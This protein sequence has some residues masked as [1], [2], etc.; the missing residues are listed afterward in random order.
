M[1]AVMDDSTIHG[2]HG[3]RGK[4]ERGTPG[5]GT[6]A[7]RPRVGSIVGRWVTVLVTAAMVASGLTVIDVAAAP[8]AQAA[9]ITVPSG[10]DVQAQ[11]Q[12]HSGYT[13][14]APGGTANP[15]SDDDYRYGSA[16]NGT[17]TGSIS[18][19]GGS[20][21][22]S[23]AEYSD[24]WTGW[25]TS[26][27][28]A[29]TSHGNIS[30]SGGQLSLSNQSALGFAPT[31]ISSFTTGQFF[32]LGRVA[33][34]NNPINVDND[35]FQGDLNLKFMGMN[36]GYRWQM[37]ETPNNCSGAGCSD[38][39]V[40]F[41]NQISSQTFTNNGFT[42]TLVVQGFVA[43]QGSNNTCTPTLSSVAGVINQF[44]TVEGTTTYGCLYASVE[45]VRPITVKKVVNSPYGTAP[46]DAFTFSRTSTHAG[47]DWSGGNF[48]LNANGS[49]TGNYNTGEAV[50]IA[51]TSPAAPWAF[52]SAVCVDGTG[53]AIA[54]VTVNG[55]Q[56]S[57]P[58]GT[59]AATVAALAIT[60]TYTNTY[61][62]KA[63]LTLQK[64]VTATG[65]P[66]PQAQAS[67]WTLTAQGQGAV[68]AQKVQGAG[69]SPAVISQTVIAGSYALSET[70][71]GGSKTS[72]Y[73]Q[74]GP[75]TCWVTGS[76]STPVTVTGGVVS[77]TNGQN[78]TCQVKNK[79]QTGTLQ[80]TKTVTTSPAGGYTQGTAMAFTAKYVC[81][82]S[83]TTGTVT[84]NPNATNG[85]PGAAATINN[86]PAGDSCVVTE[87]SPPS[88]STN[89]VNGSWL[90]NAPA[91]PAPATITAGGTATVNIGNS[92]TQ[93][94]G[95]LT[96]G[97]VI[98]PRPGTPAAGYTGG[99][100]RSFGVGYSCSIGSTVV[101]SGTVTV[102]TGTAASITGVPAT[103]NCVVTEDPSSTQPG[104]FPD[105]SYH[106]DGN[107]VAPASVTVPVNGTANATVTN[108]FKRELVSLVLKKVVTGA[109]YSGT[110]EDFTVA[111][112][113]GSVTN[114]SVTLAA[115]GSK[116]VQVPAGVLCAISETQPSGSL[117]AAGYVWDT[118]VYTGLT[119]GSVTVPLGETR[120]VTVTNNNRVG[121]AR[122][123][124]T[125]AIGDNAS[126]VTGGPQF[127]ISVTCNAPA[128]GQSANYSQTFT[129]SWPNPGT[130]LT[131]YLPIGTS[132]TVTE[133]GLPT[134]NQNLTDG[135]YAWGAAPD[136]QT[137]QVPASTQPLSVT[138][139][140]TITRVTGAF[141]VAK[142]VTNNTGATPS[143]FSGTYTCTYAPQSTVVSGTWVAPAAGGPATLT[144]GGASV[145]VLV[146]SSCVV[147][148]NA[149]PLPGGDSSYSWST[150]IP[151]AVG[152][153]AG[154]TATSTVANTLN[155]STGSFS[156]TKSV[157][158]GQA[159]VAFENSDFTFSYTCTPQS[160]AV[161][162][163]TLTM[164]AGGSAS[165][166]EVIPVGSNCVVTETATAAPIDPFTWDGVSYT[167]NGGSANSQSAQ[168]TIPVGGATV[169]VNATNTISRKTVNLTV[170][171]TVVAPD[172]GFV[173]AGM[174]FPVTVT[175]D[176]V[177]LGTKNLTNGGS[178]TWA[179][180][181]GSTCS[182]SEAQVTG[183]LA[184]ASFAWGPVDVNP[185]SVTLDSVNGQ[186]SIAVTNTVT[187]VYGQIALRKVF[188]NGGFS[189][190]VP[191]TQE[192]TGTWSCTYGNQPAVT[193]TWSALA[194]HPATM[195]GD[196]NH[197]LLTSSC[198][199]TEDALGAPS[200]D[201]SFSWATPVVTGVPSLSG[202]AAAN[203]MV[204]TNTLTRQT[205]SL[206]VSKALTG[207][208][209]GYTPGEG[210]TGFA[211]G[212]QCS[213][214]GVE[215]VMQNQAFV[216][217]GGGAVSLITGVPAGWT[218]GVSE[219]SP[220]GLDP[221]P[222]H[223]GS[224]SWGGVTYT[225]D[226]APTDEVVV[227]TG[228]TNHVVVTNEI[229]RNLGTV[230]VD[231]RIATPDAVKDGATFSGSYTCTYAGPGGD[232]IYQGTWTVTGAGT[233]TLTGD[234]AIPVS[235]V[236]QVTENT[237]PSSG[238][239][240]G[241][242][243]WAQPVLSDPA[244]VT[245]TQQPAA[246][247]VTND[248]TRLYADF[249][250]LKAYVGPADAFANPD[251]LVTGAWVCTYRGNVVAS[252]TWSA[253]ATGGAATLVGDRSTIPATSDCTISED[254]LPSGV[255]RDASYAW[256]A[257]PSAQVITLRAG[258]TPDVTV[259]NSVTRVTGGFE[260]TKAVTRGT[261]VS[262]L[263]PGNGRTFSGQYVC[264]YDGVDSAPGTW[265]VVEGGSWQS[266]ATLYVG[267]QCRV[268][269]ENPPGDPVP[270]DPSYVWAGQSWSAP[271]A[272]P[273]PNTATPVITVTNTVQRLTEGFG[274]TKAF[275]GDSAGLPED[276]QYTFEWQCIALNGD[277]FPGETPGTFTIKAGD[278]WQPATSVPVSSNCTVTEPAA[279]L[280][281]PVH[282]SFTWSTGLGVTGAQGD[283]S[284][285]GQTIHFQLPA[286]AEA[287]PALVTATNTLTRTNGTYQI[288]KS[289][290]PV[291]GSLVDPGQIITYTVTVTP[292]Q[293]GFVDGVIVTDD[294]SQV[295][296]HATFEDG[297][298]TPSQGTASLTGNT[299]TWN[300]G[301]VDAT[302]GPLTL[303]YQ[304]TVEDQWGVTLRNAVTATGEFPP[305]PCAEGACTT[306]HYTP[307]YTL[308]KSSNP[309]S[310][311]TV[312]PGS[313]ITYT[314]TMTNTGPVDMPAPIALDNLNGVLGNATVNLPLPAELQFDSEAGLIV[315]TPTGTLP[316]K[317]TK[318]VSYT[319]TV[320]PGSAGAT[321]KNQL[322]P[323][324]RGGSCDSEDGCVT[325]HFAP[326]WN[327]T[328]TADPAS[329]ST[330]KPG[331]VITY[332][333]T[334]NN[335]SPDAVLEGAVVTDDLS[336][337][338]NHATL[339]GSA[340]AG[341]VIS[342]TTLTW[343]V[344]Q[345]APS[346]TAQLS[347]QVKVNA[348]ASNVTLRNL[349]T[350][351]GP[352]PPDSCAA[353]VLVREGQGAQLQPC[354][355]T[356]QVPPP[357]IP[358]PPLVVTGSNLPVGSLIALGG[359]IIALG[360]V[361]LLLR[362]RRFGTNNRME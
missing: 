216:V 186:Y 70:P 245:S 175:C 174:A 83:G 236:C 87:Q 28:T 84:V 281:T 313:T 39:F 105:A 95:T 94:T 301:R 1:G 187:R 88:G 264:T 133:T 246:L 231:K 72:G 201:P 356:H 156:V 332:T 344:P 357:V 354:T 23:G 328:K 171:K 195:T 26:G 184:D 289:S 262:P 277:K 234:T 157:T 22:T 61:T 100:T 329:G 123:A 210:F 321:L 180:D 218:C 115:G 51:E 34:H 362:R 46:N 355:T 303:T 308:H 223:D 221:N 49:K 42:Y 160:G 143:D 5:G 288:A 333:L 204:V 251:Q 90:W 148:E 225:I 65:Q 318:T 257:H 193:G 25:I 91:N 203:T 341:T 189:G 253:A 40:N 278:L 31:S 52:T 74:D 15:T 170:T 32:N 130:Q 272:V 98:T 267:T 342:G 47:S 146:G 285:D 144:P 179:G 167:V 284:V 121:F 299:L 125:K 205:G 155:R 307:A 19:P 200:S 113:C 8:P 153:A 317:G 295:L 242:W 256:G 271:V 310:G 101:S 220:S 297:S 348:D 75:W 27:N 163:G 86:V 178:A 147:T 73:T 309:P 140:N 54:G 38:D 48:Q 17:L 66:A 224:F 305:K 162:S 235:A 150:T 107:V 119:N 176:N 102:T 206:D 181:L 80:I 21:G 33:H 361:L 207:E 249:G 71:T 44:R 316:V 96:I 276:P 306:V 182:A 172:G 334:V 20:A 292:G 37:D 111:Y 104:D 208:T 110:A 43:P 77:L 239:I 254:T 269:S 12:N 165:P 252:G 274:V 227:A 238:L 173:D 82:P 106:W 293:V 226:G 320:L 45:Q 347:Y 319:V 286:S 139:T 312:V 137:V 24:G 280:P 108:Y 67:D 166:S 59:E 11:L 266:P 152:I 97:K 99:A 350:A 58:K 232:V 57:I 53:A 217:P 296:P 60:C 127:T 16:S 279:S 55:T 135:S 114:G 63:T 283:P 325:Q 9:T 76:P 212:V 323:R 103:A 199:A 169:Q 335:V 161:I 191:N 327:V 149:P 2:S 30:G 326:E 56:V 248:A 14:A 324:T 230:T 330:V 268:T 64:Q 134:G 343:T 116:T 275:A 124:V 141:A 240:D 346:G 196:Y 13:A 192:Y 122:L 351:T 265:Q 255:F 336:Q 79:F 214:P 349:V 298:I 190:I 151:P 159:G 129:F 215:G 260:I 290:D 259:H 41:L 197:I 211:V 177:A 112:N 314:L 339:V 29:W 164:L 331:Q 136:P 109:G 209:A 158:G 194:A 118:P 185:S 219:S 188:D 263:V 168:F 270:T 353:N 62:P 243:Q 92:A 4:R 359:G 337:V 338:L 273:S 258:A 132:C 128:A 222:L 282:P 3:G 247:T 340:P 300:V 69:G 138:V 302:K 89:L 68:S 311:A 261:G 213:Y 35:F 81:S 358:P 304:V 78:V 360:L 228:Q 287:T 85:Q 183:G 202:D 233:A 145:A 198:T 7:R 10:Q 237:P 36:L 120:T 6:H 315:W 50:T 131:S 352:E 244:T 229:T 345:V 322:T 117:L 154:Q 241:S 93:A 250:I 126:A 142:T 291:S 294:L 18:N